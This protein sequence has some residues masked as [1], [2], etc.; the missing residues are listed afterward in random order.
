MSYS[1]AFLTIPK[2]PNFPHYIYV[3]GGPSLLL[4]FF[5]KDYGYGYFVLALLSVVVVAECINYLRYK[6]RY[7]GIDNALRGSYA[8]QRDHDLEDIA[9]QYGIDVVLYLLPHSGCYASF[10]TSDDLAL[11]LLA[12]PTGMVGEQL[13]DPIRQ[14]HLKE[15]R[16]M[17]SS[18]D[19]G[20]N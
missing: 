15:F 6:R 11:F 13:N 10:D 3:G 4:S 7:R 20:W 14:I 8:I 2:R 18:Y 9:E 12:A 1:E 5:N 16:K 17:F 19:R